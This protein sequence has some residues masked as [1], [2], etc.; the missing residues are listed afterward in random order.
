MSAAVYTTSNRPT[1]YNE[2]AE[3][4]NDIIAHSSKLHTGIAILNNALAI[5]D[6]KIALGYEPAE[7][8]QVAMRNLNSNC[9]IIGHS[10]GAQ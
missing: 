4:R 7:A 1:V 6:R 8:F 10:F 2:A 5:Y 3:L 9:G